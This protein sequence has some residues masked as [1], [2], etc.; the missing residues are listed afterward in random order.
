[1]CNLVQKHAHEHTGEAES[2]RPSLRNG[3]TAYI[4][5]SPADRA[6]CHRRQRNCFHQLDASIG[7]S[8]P[9]DFAVRSSTF[10]KGTFASTASHR[11]VPNDRDPPL[12]SGETGGFVLLICP[13]AKEEYF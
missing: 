4:V 7:A 2:I 6:C 1:V 10:V 13:T 9:H 12:L 8:G 11:N 5:L 3:S